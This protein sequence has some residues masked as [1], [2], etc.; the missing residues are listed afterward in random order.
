M[1]G[2][3]A[4]RWPMRGWGKGGARPRSAGAGGGRVVPLCGRAGSAAGGSGEAVSGLA[5]G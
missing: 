1:R 4:A 2:G 3:A 5:G